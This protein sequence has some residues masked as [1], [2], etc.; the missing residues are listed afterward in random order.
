MPDVSISRLPFAPVSD[1]TY[2]DT[3]VSGLRFFY[4]VKAVSPAGAALREAS[5][6]PS[7]PAIMDN[8]S[9]ETAR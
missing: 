7:T 6:S 9:S 4:T 1:T 2:M 3:Q 5:V 8:K